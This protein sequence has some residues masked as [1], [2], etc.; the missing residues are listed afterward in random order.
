ML[1]KKGIDGIDDVDGIPESMRQLLAMQAMEA[2]Q[3]FPSA[4]MR[5]P[6]GPMPYGNGMLINDPNNSG[7]VGMYLARPRSALLRLTF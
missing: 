5:R 3:P 1:A 7:K 4:L 6:G 2:G